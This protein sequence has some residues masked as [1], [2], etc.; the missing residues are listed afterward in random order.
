M[1]LIRMIGRDIRDAIKSVFRNFSLSM[2]SISCII[3]TLVLVG[4]S[5]IISFNID[6]FTKLM[7][8]DFSIIV[9]LDNDITDEEIEEVEYKIKENNNIAEY[10]F[11]SKVE[12]AK[13]VMD[14]SEI[15]KNIMQEWDEEENPLKDTYTVKVKDA[16]ILTKT[17]EEIEKISN[18]AVV[19]YGAGFIEKFL[20]IFDVVEKALICVVILFILVTAFLIVNTIKLTIFSR[21]KEIEIM[22]LVGASNFNIE[23]PFIVEGL[24]LG[25]LG[26]IIPIILVIYGYTSLY[27]TSGGQVLSS[28]FIKLVEPEPFIYI[29]SVIILG[30][31]IFVGM[32]GSFRAVRKYLKI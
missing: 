12:I 7:Q 3:I 29:I 2:A 16:K 24:F 23:L 22:R 17:A 27:L 26:A 8:K 19:Q 14:T 31:G 18:V 30:I 20:K 25:V 15:F 10:K 32:F 11:E 28:P 13:N 4:L 6:N 9:Y 21:R 1:R 5:L